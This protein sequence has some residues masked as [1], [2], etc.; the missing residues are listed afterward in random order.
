MPVLEFQFEVGEEERHEVN[1]RFNRTY[2][3]V[4]IS[5]D[6]EQVLRKVT[7]FSLYKTQR[8]EVAVGEKE[9]HDVLIEKTRKRWLGGFFP[10][11]CVAYVDHR[12]VGRYSG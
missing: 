2:G 10:Q 11:E 7:H 1:F 8:Y 9:R 5:V 3:P 12:E 4:T 6:D